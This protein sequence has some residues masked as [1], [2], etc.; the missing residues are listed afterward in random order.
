MSYWFRDDD[1]ADRPRGKKM[2]G[3]ASQLAA[4]GVRPTYFQNSA[5]VA[6]FY[7]ERTAMQATMQRKAKVSGSNVFKSAQEADARFEQI[8]ANNESLLTQKL[9][10][11]HSQHERTAKIAEKKRN[12]KQLDA[13]LREANAELKLMRRA[14]LRELLEAEHQQHKRELA[15]KGL[16]ILVEEP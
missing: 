13:D 5:D 15:A 10:Q 4:S 11:W 9:A 8:Q 16:A 14:K 6:A 7:P 2:Y 1:A 3:N 12:E